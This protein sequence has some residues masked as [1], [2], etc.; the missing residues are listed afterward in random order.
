M[1]SQAKSSKVMQSWAKSCKVMQS[2]LC[3]IECTA[4][5]Y[6]E[7]SK[8]AKSSKVEQSQAKSDMQ[9]HAKSGQVMQ[10]HAK[11]GTK[12]VCDMQSWCLTL[13]ALHPRSCCSRGP[14]HSS[15]TRIFCNCMCK[16]ESMMKR[17][18]ARTRVQVETVHSDDSNQ[19]P[20][21][22]WQAV[23]RHVV[24]W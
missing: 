4:D 1:Q 3:I 10:S 2:Q 21:Y 14:F 20:Y 24:D 9:K 8:N 11:S 18:P 13:Q 22:R 15:L 7:I 17:T 16:F 5:Y 6:W 19:F 12:F 23:S